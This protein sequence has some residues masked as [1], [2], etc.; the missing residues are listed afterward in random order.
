MNRNLLTPKAGIVTFIGLAIFFSV[1]GSFYTVPQQDVGVLTRFGK[2]IDTV[3]PGLNFK[4]PWIE[5]VKR[6]PTTVQQVDVE[7]E[8]VNTT[9]N[10]QAWLTVYIQYEIQ[11]EGA[12]TL[13]EK[14]PNYEYRL[15]SLTADLLKQ[16]LGRYQIQDIPTN[17]DKIEMEVKSAVT[18]EALRL[19]AINITEIQLKN[20]KY[21][22]YFDDAITRMTKKKA[23]VEVA[24]QA[25]LQAEYDAKRH[26]TEAQGNAQSA[27]TEAQGQAD[28]ITIN[29]KANAQKINLEGQAQANAIREQDQALS[30]SANYV[31]L[32]RAQRWDGKLPQN[33]GIGAGS[34][35]PMVNIPLS[36]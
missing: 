5:S 31:S 1:L 6:Y 8:Q 11:P 20:I 14:Y 15:H 17:R 16:V 27:R 7:N 36:K 21:N 26:V 34:S 33:I 22:E 35:L 10:Q 25:Q 28:A 24:K 32:V 29:A 23:D 18:K 13:F 4:L 2:Y 30:N 3:P 12:R 19:Y 9:D